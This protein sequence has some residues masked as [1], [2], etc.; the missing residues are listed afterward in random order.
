M[1]GDNIKILRK[2]KGYSQET[3]AERLNVVRQTVSKWEKGLSVPDAEMLIRIADVFDVTVPTLLGARIIEKNADSNRMMGELQNS[4]EGNNPDAVMAVPTAELHEVANQLAILNE[5]LALQSRRRRRIVL[6]IFLGIILTFILYIGAV[7]AFKANLDANRGPITTTSVR[8][9][10]NGEEY[11][12][13]V[14]YDCNY[15]IIAAGGDAWIANHVMVEQYGYADMLL[16]QIEDYFVDR[17]GTYEV[18]EEVI[19]QEE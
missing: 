5:R 2:Q 16:A 1:L 17:G 6:G 4:A 13:G 10:L 7:I 12:Y 11:C 8:C 3:L 14:T 9:T 18:I 19:E 15:Q